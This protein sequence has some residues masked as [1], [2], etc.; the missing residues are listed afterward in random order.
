MGSSN[1]DS[2]IASFVLHGAVHRYLGGGDNDDDNN[3]S[4]DNDNDNG[5]NNNG[6]YN[7]GNNN[8]NNGNYNN[9]YNNNNGSSYSEQYTTTGFNVWLFTG[10]ALFCMIMFL[11]ILLRIKYHRRRTNNENRIKLGGGSGN[12]G[13]SRGSTSKTKTSS[14]SSNNKKRQQISD[15]EIYKYVLPIKKENSYNEA[16][17][18]IKNDI[19][20]KRIL[21]LCKP[22][23]FDALIASICDIISASLIGRGLGVDALAIYYI[24]GVPTTFTL[25]LIES[26]LSTISTLGG[27]S[28]GVGS[29][30][31][32]GQYCQISIV[33]VS[34]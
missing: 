19:E 17:Y 21:K 20:T 26:I 6:N 5:N 4:N 10:T 11:Y 8:N 2:N 33:L 7:N 9:N 29:Y 22:F 16:F 34:T 27:Q 1:N 23:W 18:I 32:T 15:E 28:I 25:T 12:S 3:N 30:K 13:G 14:S 24:V 31:L